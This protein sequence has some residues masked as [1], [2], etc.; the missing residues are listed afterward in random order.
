M[1]CPECRNSLTETESNSDIFYC[2]S[3]DCSLN[4]T[5]QLFNNST[6]NEEYRYDRNNHTFEVEIY[7][8]RFNIYIDMDDV[9]N[10]IGKMIEINELRLQNAPPEHYEELLVKLDR[11]A[12]LKA[13]W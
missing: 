13:F 12:K 8:N 9:T 3:K 1:L 7:R 2:N 4:Y 5:I 6:S 11:F 10:N